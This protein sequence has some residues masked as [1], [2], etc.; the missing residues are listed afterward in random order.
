MELTRELLVKFT[1]SEN[2]IERLESKIE[3]FANKKIPSEYGVVK[4][5]MAK[6]PYAEC[7]FTLCGSDVKSSE[8][9]DKE[10]R[11]MLITL[12][13]RKNEF[14]IINFEV[15]KAI[16]EIEDAETRQII[17]YK[18]VWK[19]SDAE[20]GFKMGYERSAISKKLTKY[21]ES[22]KSH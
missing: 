19:L 15:A 1:N 4:G 9:Y 16:E 11:Q 2:E 10:L 5:S 13:Q 22:H 7:H 17:E 20:I 3:R 12:Q 14:E 6:F 8:E 21:L 18:Y